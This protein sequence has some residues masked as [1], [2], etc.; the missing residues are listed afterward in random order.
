MPKLYAHEVYDRLPNEIFEV[1]W[2]WDPALI[3]FLLLMIFYIRALPKFKRQVVAKWQVGLF[4]TGVIINILAL[5]PPIDPLADQLFWVHMV[6]HLMITHVGV[7]FMLFGV[8]FFIVMRGVPLWFRRYVYFPLLRSRITWLFERTIARPL[9][10]LILFEVNYWFWHVPR[11]YNLALLNDY[12]HL[13]EHACFAI[14]SMLLWRNLIDPHP[15]KSPIPLP[16]RL[17]YLGFIMAANII[18]SAILTFADEVLYAYEGIPLP[19]WWERWGHLQDQRVG[20]LIM[21][22]PGGFIML[23]AMT[24]VFFVWA[25]REKQ[26]E[27]AGYSAQLAEA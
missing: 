1:K 4:F 13:L 25:H 24:V 2:D 11:F 3:F 9:P 17:L 12:F 8:P 27:E 5:M 22:I 14:T 21:W 18:L 10:S 6:Q 19:T 20:G 16:A 15:M 26:K 7:P 23:I